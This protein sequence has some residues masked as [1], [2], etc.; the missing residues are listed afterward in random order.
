MNIHLLT[1]VAGVCTFAAPQAALADVTLVDAAKVADETQSAWASIDV[2]RIESRYAKSIVVFD[3]TLANL[4]TT[5]DALHKIEE[6]FVKAKVDSVTSPDR[7]IQL[8]D[9]KTFVASGT[10]VGLSS[11]GP[12]K[13]IVLRF[14]DVY[15]LQDDGRWLIVNEHISLPP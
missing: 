14:T 4:G 9:D 1:A 12:M 7:V 2:A 10:G 13:Q 3:P 5:W 11:K 6:T 15:R 8:L